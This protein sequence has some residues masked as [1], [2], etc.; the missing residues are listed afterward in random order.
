MR[1]IGVRHRVKRTADGEA[2][3]TQ[4]AFQVND[5][6]IARLDLE[7]EQA[8]LDW[9]YG[10]YPTSFRPAE[11]DEDLSVFP[12][13]HLKTSKK[14]DQV[15]VPAKYTGFESGDVVAMT[16]GGSGNTLAFALSRRGEKINAQVVRTP[17]FSLKSARVESEMTKDDDS[18][19]LMELAERR[20][21]LFR[22][23]TL[24]ERELIKLSNKYRERQD[25]LKERIACEQ[26]LRQRLRD[27]IF[28]SEEGLYPERSIE[29]EFLAT[30]AN[31]QIL[32]ALE[33][34]ENK[35][36]R[37]LTNAVEA[38]PVYKAV[39]ESVVGA[40]PAIAAAIIAAVQD[41]NRFATPA[42]L[43]AYMGVHLIDGKLARRRRGAVA[44]W[45]GQARQAL[46]QLVLQFIRRPESEWG[47]RF[48][49]IK[50]NY[51]LRHP[52]EVDTE[53]HKKYGKMQVHKTA[54]W[55]TATKFVEKCIF[56]NWP[57]STEAAQ[58]PGETKEPA[59]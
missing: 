29:D 59:A 43:K 58:A 37:E 26:R 31:D 9:A 27:Q 1:Y 16:L 44:N 35:R 42:K 46:Y 40:G 56:R 38:D 5:G 52:E 17:P 7:D 49:T 53:G 10:K 13:H 23:V 18:V 51:R 28:C 20:P 32:K 57:R 19:L 4:V 25:A 30:K 47:M 2:R 41:I 14:K 48:N 3:P 50:V 22:P 21:E 45:S 36:Y 54:I 24:R 34:E 33:A 12:K 11:P 55:R 6:T 8:E 15:M 39:F